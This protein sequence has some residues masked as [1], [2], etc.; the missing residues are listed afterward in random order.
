MKHAGIECS[1]LNARVAFNHP[2]ARGFEGASKGS[3][4]A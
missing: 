1:L 4:H 3:T 2:L